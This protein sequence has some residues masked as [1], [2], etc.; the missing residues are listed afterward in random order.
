[1][2]RICND[3]LGTGCQTIISRYNDED[4]CSLCDKAYREQNPE[5]E[6]GWRHE[7]FE[8]T[9]EKIHDAIRQWAKEMGKPPRRDDWAKACMGRWPNA[10]TVAHRCGSWTQAVGDA[11]FKTYRT[12]RPRGPVKVGTKR[13]DI[14]A[15]L[16]E[17]SFGVT[18]IADRLGRGWQGTDALLRRMEADGLVVSTCRDCIDDRRYGLRYSLPEQR[19]EAA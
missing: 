16:A 8:W 14:L 1:M 4:S 13:R 7:V 12:G 5:D 6:H 2:K 15:L 10:S 19:A 9:P 3:P 17:G 18:E 11:G